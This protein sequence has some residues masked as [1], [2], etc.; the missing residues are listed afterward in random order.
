MLQIQYERN[1][2]R[3][4]VNN[5]RVANWTKWGDLLWFSIYSWR[6]QER[7]YEIEIFSRVFL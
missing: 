3:N 7:S 4:S 5:T 1:E 6:M 2:E